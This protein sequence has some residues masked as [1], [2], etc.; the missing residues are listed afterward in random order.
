MPRGKHPKSLANL[1]PIRKGE[2]R[3]PRGINTKRSFS[4]RY[5]I[6]AD[7]VIPESARRK[8][9]Q[10]AGFMLHR[11]RTTWREASA[12]ALLFGASGG[13]VAA[14]K[15]LADRVEGK[16]PERIE[17]NDACTNGRDA[18]YPPAG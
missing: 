2:V 4:E 15:E 16:A 5:L 1:R 10:R 12:R 11:K 14:A 17:L 3:N 7:E 8:L 9:N 13:E 18:T 6:S